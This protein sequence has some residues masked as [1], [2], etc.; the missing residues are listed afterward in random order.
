MY[1]PPGESIPILVME[2][3]HASL[4]SCLG[5]HPGIP[6]HCKQRILLDVTHGLQFL[7]ERNDPIIHRDLTANNI[8]VTEDMRAKISDLGV[9][10][11]IPR[12]VLQTHTVAPGNT[13]YMPP[14]ALVDSPNY[15]TKLDI[16]SLG[17]LIM[18]VILQA[19]PLPHREAT[20][21][22]PL[23]PGSK[24]LIANSE[25]E[26]R[27][28]HFKKMDATHPLTQMAEWCLS[29]DP[30]ARPTA[31]E[32]S[33]LLE[34][35]VLQSSSLFLPFLESLEKKGEIEKRNEALQDLSHDVERQLHKI[36][37]DMCS[38][39]TLNE[40]QLDGVVNQ[41]QAISRSTRSVLYGSESEPYD[42]SQHRFVVAYTPPRSV[43][44]NKASDFLLISSASP[45]PHPLSMTV[46][47]SI[48]I[49]FSG[50]YVKTIASGLRQPRGLATNGDHLYVVDNYGWYGVQ[51]CSISGI[52]QTRAVVLSSSKAE[53][54][55]MS[56]EKCWR[57]SGVAIDGENNIILVDTQSHRVLKFDTDGELLG[58][59]GKIMESGNGIG[60]FDRPLGV[61]VVRNG[62]VYVCDRGNHR[63]QVLNVNLL[64]QRMF[65]QLGSG[66]CEFH[67][68]W[69]IA[70]DS[71]G[72]IYVVDCSNYCVKVFTPGFTSFLRHIG[73]EGKESD[74]FSGPSS[75]C[76][77][78]ND[79][80]FV[81][82]MV[83]CCV[84]VF[85]SA[86]DFVMSFGNK[87][88]EKTEF[89]FNKP[90][91]I[92]VDSKGCV[93]LSD[94]NNGRVLMFE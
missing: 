63:I 88:H 80:V 15:T 41:L 27:A 91:G 11:I 23:Y 6:M 22:D 42:T 64:S 29:N 77:D 16:F 39:P 59:S 33:D 69:D 93:F 79:F 53:F 84:K 1:T 75:I 94:S 21:P 56:L 40:V 55:G 81:T 67:H 35:L 47:T 58:S 86:G 85:T 20:S 49:P 25:V 71:K 74:Q 9:A 7:H 4:T 12:D 43:P 24:R 72:N 37:Q 73:K 31:R 36:L 8:L 34:P 87:F 46:A 76:I 32:V 89:R 19:W 45:T 61:A 51:I 54:T 68:P 26:R 28:N 60:E 5:S 62:E 30:E 38:N 92:A 44:E 78:R 90:M 17:I 50:T 48:N 18:H 82:D 65:G 13:C 70:F 14:E 10:K 57:P 52:E 2:C 66:R 3:M 83:Q